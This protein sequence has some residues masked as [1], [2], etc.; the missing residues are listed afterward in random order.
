MPSLPLCLLVLLLCG[1][2]LH[3]AEATVLPAGGKLLAQPAAS[4]ITYRQSGER[5]DSRVV[6]ISDGPVSEAVHVSIR[7]PGRGWDAELKAAV[8]AAMTTGETLLLRVW[9]RAITSRSE[10]GDVAVTINLQKA[11][12][13]WNKPL[14]HGITASAAWR[15]VLLPFTIRQDVPVGGCELALHV[16]DREQELELGGLE[17]WSYGTTVRPAD[18][19]RT[20][21][22]WAGMEADAPWR[23]AAEQRIDQLRKGDLT[24][25]VLDAAGKPVAGSQVHVRML[26]HAFAFGTAAVGARIMGTRPEDEI[27]RTKLSELF[28]AVVLENDLKWAPFVEQ[29]E[30]R[31]QTLAALRWLQERHFLVRGHV[32]VWPSWR[33]QPKSLKALEKDP[34]ALRQRILERIDD[35]SAATAGL[36]AHWDVVNEPFDNHDFMDLCGREVMVDWFQ[37]ARQR[38]PAD[39]RLFLNDYGIVAAAGA[40]DTPHQRHYED[41]INFLQSRGAPLE[42]LGVQS[43]FGSQ[44]TPPLTAMRIL[45]G[46]AAHKLPIVITEFDI[47]TQDEDYQTAYTRDYLTLCF[48]HPAVTGFLMW[49]FW[50]GAHWLPQAAMLRKD[51]S[52]KPNLA[53]WRELTQQRWWTDATLTTDAQGQASLRG[54]KG[55]YVVTASGAQGE[56][57]IGDSANTVELRLP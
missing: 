15:E 1:V 16:G 10:S 38:L 40:T 19:P 7:N 51:W 20:R 5:G 34:A 4:A 29:P 49:G 55:D 46:L 48:A 18:L 37:R 12:P 21:T 32:M 42:G 11:G 35:A 57:R 41:T 27:Y 47:N 45:D 30:R 13:P 2:A 28:N 52:E 50:E 3:A 26:R 39:C 14:S 33:N 36:V 9:L 23:A 53:V 43:H 31:V 17:L 44:P 24:V 25:R 6:A 22:T 8:P 56:V 54:F